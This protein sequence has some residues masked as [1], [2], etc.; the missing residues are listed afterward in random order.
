MKSILALLF[1]FVISFSNGGSI[2]NN[3][4]L[5]DDGFDD[6]D[7]VEDGGSYV[8][9]AVEAST[10]SMGYI[11]APVEVE[12]EEG[13]SC[14]E[15]F[16]DLLEENGYEPLY[17]G[18]TK[19]DFYLTA[20][21]GV[22]TENAGITEELKSF[23]DENKVKCSNEV[24]SNGILGEFDLSE[25]SGWMYT[26]NGEIPSVSMSD[27]F[28]EENDV[29]RLRYSLCYGAD[30]GYFEDWGYEYGDLVIPS[31]DEITR[32]VAQKGA[33][34][35]SEYLDVIADFSTPQDELDYILKT[36]LGE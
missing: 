34:N 5:T 36:I 10:A 9:C 12:F 24:S 26:V 2:Q 11:V 3:A 4:A 23:L 35:C 32:A 14:A 18:D 8:I 28:P 27:Y 30:I 17:S 29:I 25:A 15:I 1:S 13:K 21:G 22:D 31:L 16:V 6:Y 20:I 7:Y 33:E 19:K